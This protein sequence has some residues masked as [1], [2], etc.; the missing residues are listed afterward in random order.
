MNITIPVS[1]IKT[2]RKLLTRI[3]FERL[4]LPVLTHVLATIDAAGLTLAVTDLDHWLETRLPATITPFS[5]ES[6]RFLIPAAALAAAARGDQGSSVQFECPA[7]PDPNKPAIKLKLTVTCGK[8][9]VET[10]YQPEPASGFPERPSIQGQITTVPKETFA[11][12][13]T[14]AGCASTDA[15]RS[16][17]NGVLFSPDNGGTLIA[18]DG[19]RLAGTPARVT[20]REF[21]LPNAAVRVLGFQDFSA[22]DAA[23]QQ[24]EEGTTNAHVQIRSGPHTLIARTIEGNYPNYRQVIPREFVAEATIP[25]A[26]KAALIS[27]LRSLDGKRNSVRLTWDKPGHLTLTLRD[28]DT[29]DALIHVPVSITGKPPVIA[30]APGYLADA[31]AIGPTL[32]LID[33]LRPGMTTST[34]TGQPGA[35]CVIMPCRCVAEDAPED[36]PEVG[37]VQAAAQAT[38]P[39]IGDYLFFHPHLHVLAADGLFDFE[40]RFHCMPADSRAPMIELFRNRFLQALRAGKHVSPSRLADLLSWKHSGFHIDGGGENPVASHDADGR[41]RLAEYLL[42]H[43]FSL[44]KI[45]WNATTQTVIYRSKRHHTTKRNFE[46][47]KATDFLAAVIDHVPPK[48]NHT[49]RYY[50]EDLRAYRASLAS[51]QGMD[52]R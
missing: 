32:R 16:V 31:L 48:S 52:S 50:Q 20:G 28:S 36:A 18:T 13:Q 14:V 45:T 41:K 15:T 10:V 4:K 1:A 21:I 11:A 46:I 25:D 9:P 43:P 22:R 49:V 44:Q 51:D 34:P 8:M 47:F 6:T 3:H 23:I 33:G 39:A 19:R 30:F 2:A 24:P 35:F 37:A 5:P 12:L 38:V 17:L 29:T 42:R 40:G 7:K 26:H 27:W